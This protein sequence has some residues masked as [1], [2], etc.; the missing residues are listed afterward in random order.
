MDRK[1]FDQAVATV[2]T[3]PKAPPPKTLLDLYSLYKQSTTG[4]ATGD[5]PGRLNIR[6]R[7][8]YDSWMRRAGM[9]AEAAMQAYVDLVN[10]LLAAAGMP[11][12]A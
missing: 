5:R 12:V 8:K 1:T 6:A 7:A 10:E 2:K 3:L 11:P 9:S 4:D